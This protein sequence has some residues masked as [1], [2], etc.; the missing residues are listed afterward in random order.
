M[1]QFATEVLGKG[2]VICK[3]TPNFIANRIGTYSFDINHQ[4]SYSM[5]ATLSAKL[6]PFWGHTQD[7]PSPLFSV[8]L[9]CRDWIY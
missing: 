9:T 4:A 7:A 6:I 3:D 8:L 1:Q 2:V 5:R